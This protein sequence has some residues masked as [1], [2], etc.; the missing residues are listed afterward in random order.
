MMS[1]DPKEFEIEDGDWVFW[2]N[3]DPPPSGLTHEFLATSHG[4]YARRR[5]VVKETDGR[6]QAIT[7]SEHR[8]QQDTHEFLEMDGGKV[9]S[10][11]KRESPMDRLKRITSIEEAKAIAQESLGCASIP[12]DEQQWRNEADYREGWRFLNDVSGTPSEATHEFKI[13]SSDGRYLCK[14]K[15]APPP[16]RSAEA[17]AT[18]LEVRRDHHVDRRGNEHSVHGPDGLRIF[19]GRGSAAGHRASIMAAALN[20]DMADVEFWLRLSRGEQ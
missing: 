10:R 20:G 13:R 4:T 15:A 14:P 18:A 9:Y 5:P 8:L 2:A 11:P 7:P 12:D 16:L 3:F 17:K 6:W 1:N 19:A